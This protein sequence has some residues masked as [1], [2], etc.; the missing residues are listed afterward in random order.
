LEQFPEYDIKEYG[1]AEY[2]LAEKVC[3]HR[4]I[5]IQVRKGMYGLPQAGLLAQQ[6]L[7]ERLG[8]HGYV[9]RK[10]HQVCGHI[11]GIGG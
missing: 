8:N 7:A 6:L 1:L 4:Y 3:K 9:Q 5:Y 2:G 10:T 11:I